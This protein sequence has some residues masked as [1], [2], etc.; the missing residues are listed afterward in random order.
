[1]KQDVDSFHVLKTYIKILE[2]DSLTFLGEVC[3]F[4]F[5]FSGE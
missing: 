4:H 3:E 5:G 2:Q 1:M